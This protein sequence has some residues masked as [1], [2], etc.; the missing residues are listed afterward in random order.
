MSFF[1]S[2]LLLALSVLFML[3][4]TGYFIIKHWRRTQ[5]E[6]RLNDA[7]WLLCMKCRFPLNTIQELVDDYGHIQCPEC[8][9]TN[10]LGKL[11]FQW[12]EKLF[13]KSQQFQD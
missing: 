7:H 4:T 11:P 5:L 13:P 1:N 2:N 6:R 9:S 10:H 3:C 8:G 12:R